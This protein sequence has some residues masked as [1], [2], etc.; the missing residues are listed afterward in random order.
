MADKIQL[1]NDQK[2]AVEIQQNAVVSAGAGSGKTKVLSERFAYLVK[3]KGYKVDEIL[4]LTFTKKATNEMFG[5]IYKVLKEEKSDAI[6]DFYKAHIQT[7]DSY[8]ASIAKIGAH[9]YGINPD[10]IE[11]DETVA[12]TVRSMALPF[13]LENRDNKALQTVVK[14]GDFADVA[15]ELFVKPVLY[16]STLTKPLDFVEDLERQSKEIF[17]LFSKTIKE[18]EDM[19]HSLKPLFDDCTANKNTKFGNAMNEFFKRPIV[20]APQLKSKDA[21]EISQDKDTIKR[22]IAYIN[23]IKIDLQGN[24]LPGG[25][26]SYQWEGVTSIIKKLRDEISSKLAAVANFFYS[27]ETMKEVMLLL[28]TFQD[29]VNKARRTQGILTISDVSSLA[30]SILIDF[31]ELRQI[32]KEKFREIMIDE[33]QDNNSQQ[34][35]MLFLLAEKLDRH[36]K[37]IPTSIDE[38][39]ENKLFFVGDE[40][41]SIYKFRGADVSVFRSLK[42]FFKAGNLELSTNYRSDPSLI[43]SFNV[44]FGGNSS[45]FLKAGTPDV[46]KYEAVYS[47]AKIPDH[48]VLE[49]SDDNSNCKF[50][51]ALYDRTDVKSDKETLTQTET[52][53]FWVARKIAELKNEGK[54]TNYSDV[55]I[56][57]RKYTKQSVFE[58]IFLQTGIPYNTEVIKGFFSDGPVN[59]MINYLR[60]CVYPYDTLAYASILRSPFVNLTS[61]EI[62]T[63]MSQ[64][65]TSAKPTLFSELVADLLDDESKNRYL[66]AGKVFAEFVVYSKTALITDC[67]SKL[68]YEFGYRYE[69]LWNQKVEMYAKLYDM[70]FE[71]ARQSDS[72]NACLADFVDG[73]RTYVDQSQ[74]LEGMDIPLETKDSVHILTIFKSK[75]LE[76]PYVFVCDCQ[77]ESAR[78]RNMEITYYSKEYG[79][80]L[81]LPG[82]KELSSSNWFFNKN[83]K[84]NSA[85]SAAELRRITYVAVTRAIN[86]CYV[87]GISNF[88]F[89][90]GKNYLP[91]EGTPATILNVFMAQL[92]EYKDIPQHAPFTLEKIPE[93]P[94]EELY[95]VQ[96]SKRRNL[97][98]EKKKVIETVKIKASS[99]SVVEADIPEQLYVSPSQLHGEN[100]VTEQITT[101]DELTVSS[102]SESTDNT[103]FSEITRIIES[104]RPKP[105]LVNLEN[106]EP[107]FN[108]TNFGTI[109][110]AYLEAAINNTVPDNITREF[111]GLNNNHK[112]IEVVTK[113]CEKMAEAFLKNTLGQEVMSATWKKAEYPFRC[114][115]GNKI[116][117]GI[118]DLVI[119]N[120]DG[121]YTIIDYKTN[122]SIEPEIYY[123]QLACYRYA[124]KFMENC[125][126]SAIK[127]KLYYLRFDKTVDITEK[128]TF[129]NDK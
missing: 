85:Q 9:Y 21:I 39:E 38:L 27:Y 65:A 22:F 62:K 60:L 86:E 128:T 106:N 80:T 30:L 43:N 17:D 52:E 24:R 33:F 117:R 83:K 56:L 123:E 77:S 31:P 94:R 78:N 79:L 126:E 114:Q 82:H 48:K 29:K 25:T 91:P 92:D 45:V 57:L 54:I 37:T 58:R 11:D 66:S 64:Y 68:W 34:R 98:A 99:A 88:D 35:D 89:L 20:S 40:K 53:A 102:N 12:N 5:R 122:T 70:L 74:K 32:E 125:P 120:E 36:E 44:I 104:T 13:L 105:F 75:G 4:T 8:C 47:D 109:A 95:A 84:L 119:K 81:N 101:S 7:L 73:L 69:T 61:S 113:A 112:N 19:I 55:A 93:T 111:I 97:L 59:D 26:V 41:Q 129:G 124:L 96:G 116:A 51:F 87:T 1:D 49:L 118:I 23:Y 90:R 46:P 18:S 6:S 115:M 28:D 121:T 103:P 15:E 10:F 63:V 50:H 3:N 72:D 2:R 108:Y 67:L 110:H 14:T 42:D 76:F 127:C 107:R 100:V 71:L 16:Y